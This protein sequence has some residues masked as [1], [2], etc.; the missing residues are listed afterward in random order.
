MTS[1]R[2]VEPGFR[3]GN[4]TQFL[5]SE[6][7]IRQSDA[8]ALISQPTASKFVIPRSIKFLLRILLT[9]R[10]FQFRISIA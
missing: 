4:E 8:D 10:P 2:R 1:S 6:R 3:S 7:D 9:D 5:F